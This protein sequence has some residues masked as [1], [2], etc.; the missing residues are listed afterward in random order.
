M[1]TIQFRQGQVLSIGHDLDEI[2]RILCRTSRIG[3]Q[4]VHHFGERRLRVDLAGYRNHPPMEGRHLG[5]APAIRLLGIYVHAEM[6][7]SVAQ[8]AVTAHPIL[9]RSSREIMALEVVGEAPES[10]TSRT[11]PGL[12]AG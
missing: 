10:L 6:P 11:G 12:E 3:L 2:V 5:P 4:T 7:M 9:E 1:H 8:I